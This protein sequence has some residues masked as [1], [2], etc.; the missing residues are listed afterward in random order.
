MPDDSIIQFCGLRSKCY[1]M[2]TKHGQK[3]AVAGV[4]RSSQ[5]LLKHATFVETLADRSIFT[6]GQKTFVSKKHDIYTQKTLKTALSVLDI[7]RIILPDG[8][9]TVP[10][11]YFG[12]YNLE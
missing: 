3:M 12:S 1:S 9:N 2:V 4:K 10:Y 11:G 5:K 8:I 7:K 6:V